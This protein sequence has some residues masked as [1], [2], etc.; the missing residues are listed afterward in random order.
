MNS[1]N[2]IYPSLDEAKTPADMR[3]V[4]ERASLY[5]GLIRSALMVAD[6][7]NMSPEDRYTFLAYHALQQ[8]QSSCR[9]ALEFA[10]T[11]PPP[12]IL[13]CKCSIGS[14]DPA[15]LAGQPDLKEVP[16]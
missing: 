16:Q 12:R 15:Q 11:M 13:V 8:L 3:I 6:I 5:N 14:L 2:N 9:Q 7:N 10:S 1:S 4:I